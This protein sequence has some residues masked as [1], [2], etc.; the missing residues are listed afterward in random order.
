[1]RSF[2]IQLVNPFKPCEVANYGVFLEDNL[3]VSLTEDLT[4]SIVY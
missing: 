1:M 3:R 2:E 4:C